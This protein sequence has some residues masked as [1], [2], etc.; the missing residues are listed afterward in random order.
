[1]GLFP[2]RLALWVS[3]PRNEAELVRAAV[4]AGADAIK[5]H[6]AVEHRA[7]GNRFGT[8]DEER[9]RLL[10]VVEA[11]AGRPVG[12]VT[13]GSPEAAP[14]DLQMVADLGIAFVDM[15][16]DHLPAAWLHRPQPVQIMAS[17]S[18]SIPMSLV[19]DLAA[20][21][22]DMFEAGAIPG[23]GYGKPLVAADLAIYRQ[24]RRQVHIPIVVPSQRKLVP[25]D[26]PAL[27]ATG[28]DAIMIGAVVT[29]QTAEGIA[30][31]TAAF[32]K[33]LDQL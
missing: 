21:G 3:V 15:Y 23:D 30:A 1:M 22:L 25:A 27:A 6:M 14:A 8:L 24:I 18:A 4:A 5:V 29:G 19:G 16:A 31:A 20:C 28:I 7:S 17:S 26:V 10:A 33:A 13:G 9:E 12:L 11:A 2:N 32:R